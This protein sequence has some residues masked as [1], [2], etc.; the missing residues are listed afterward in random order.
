MTFSEMFHQMGFFA[1]LTLLIGIAPLFFAIAYA[2]RPAER[3]LALMRAVS[4][5]ATFAA[6]GGLAVGFMAILRGLGVSP[7][8]T[9]RNVYMGMSE[10]LVPVFVNFG[11]LAVAW[12]LVAAGMIRRGDQNARSEP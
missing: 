1:K 4:L 8:P 12:L 9:M 3:K 7:N 10:A 6:L 11:F 5:S 2:L